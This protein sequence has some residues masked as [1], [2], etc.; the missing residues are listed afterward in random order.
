MCLH[1]NDFVPTLF[2]Y[3]RSW[4]EGARSNNRAVS[5]AFVVFAPTN[6]QL[7]IVVMA[8]VVHVHVN[9]KRRRSEDGRGEKETR[10]RTS[11]RKKG[12]D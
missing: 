10:G 9:E 4:G 6:T 2:R 1:N 8:V 12:E 3:S 7:E 5:G 11:I